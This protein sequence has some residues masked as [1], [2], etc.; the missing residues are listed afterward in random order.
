MIQAP[1]PVVMTLKVPVLPK[2]PPHQK[3][4]TT[5]PNTNNRFIKPTRIATINFQSI[6][7]KKP[8]L[9]HLLHTLKPDI[10]ICT[11]TWLNNNIP[12]H[13]YFPSH[14]YTT[15]RKDRTPNKKGQSHGGV[16]IAVTNAYH[17]EHAKELDTDNESIYININMTNSHNLTVG[18]YYRPPSDKGKSIEHL[19][20]SIN[21]IGQ[22]NNTITYISGDFN[23]PHIDW[24]TNT[25]TPSTPQPKLHQHLLNIIN[26]KS[27]TQT[28]ASPTRGEHILDLT[29]TNR[30]SIINKQEILPP[31]GKS[32]H[33]I[34][35]TEIDVRLKKIRRPP[36][37]IL[38]YNK[39]NWDNIKTDLEQLNTQLDERSNDNIEEI[40]HS[41][42]TTLN[43]SIDKNIPTKHITHK[44]KLPWITRPIRQL[45]NKSKRLHKQHKSKPEIKH[46]Y[47]ATKSEL[48]KQTRNAY[49]NYL[50]K[51]ITDIPIDE[52]RSSHP[53]KKHN[54]KKLFSYIKTTKKENSDIT[55]LRK[56]GHLL[57]DTT[58]KANILNQQFQS[59]FT[60]EQN[61]TI[62]DKG[63]SPHPIMPDIHITQQGIHKLLNNI[64]P[65]KATGPDN[66]HGRILKELKDITAPILTK[67]FTCS[68]T[69]G[70]LPTR[71]ET[72]K[73][74][75]HLQKRRQI[76]SRKLQTNITHMH[77]MQINGTY[78]HQRHHVT[79]GKQQHTLRQTT[80]L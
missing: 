63:P 52:P 50:E 38:I 35:Y 12:S 79:S 21:R 54:P 64:N 11:E 31:L 43:K 58:D 23:L 48:Q 32:D 61:T 49:L 2:H 6:S 40:W 76:Q 30:P 29:L 73:C 25:T 20:D 59:A 39:A 57:T 24:H 66:I 75:S 16:L 74:Q 4:Q 10:V 7:N 56:D 55:A 33:D 69:T 27:L 28:T 14:S 22:N 46:K 13:E 47:K 51:M 72:R 60:Q 80:R 71:L 44:S 65:H 19:E 53:N 67:I 15:Y 17:S 1:S 9:E 36:R 18:A 62:P 68:L 41:F 37:D 3:K 45:I 78:N 26:D 8:E 42:K 5:S 77:H 34:V 70:T